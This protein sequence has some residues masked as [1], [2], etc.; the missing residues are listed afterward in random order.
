MEETV[1]L[2]KRGKFPKKYTAYVKDKT[3]N[4]IRKI[5]FGDQRYPQYKDRTKLKLYSS[6]NHNTKRRMQRYYLRHSKTKNRREAIQKEIKASG[7]YYN[8]KILSH[9]F[10]W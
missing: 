10:L 6:K 5:H 1:I 2:I 9:K 7:G 8:A 3:T 4:K